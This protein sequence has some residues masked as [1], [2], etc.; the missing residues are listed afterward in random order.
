MDGEPYAELVAACYAKATS[1][2][3]DPFH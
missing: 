3:Y 1:C 2:G